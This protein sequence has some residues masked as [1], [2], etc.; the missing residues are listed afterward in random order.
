MSLILAIDQGTSSSRG[1]V[2][3]IGTDAFDRAAGGRVSIRGEAQR[4]F[5]SIFPHDG[6][7]E[8]DPEVI[9]QTTLDA[10]RAAIANAGIEGRDISAI[11]ITNQR[12]TTL[13]W[14][15]QTG[16]CVYNAIVWQ[17]RRT[18]ERCEQMQRDGMQRT[19]SAKTGL[20]LDPY[21]SGT[22]L[23][24]LLDE[25]P[26]L[27]QRVAGGE[28]CFGTVD[29]FLLWR[30]T[31]GQSHLTDATNASRTLLFDIGKQRWDPELLE[32]LNIEATLL[33]EVCDSAHDFG[34]ADAEWFG[35]AIPITGIAG[36]QQAALIGQGALDGGMCKSTCG[37]GCF[38]MTNTG[39]TQL[40]SDHGLLAT[41]GC[42]LDGKVTY[43]LEGSIFTAG[44]A[45]KWLRDKL[46][47]IGDAAETEAL[48]RSTGGDSGGVYLVPAFTGLG[49]PH[50]N[51]HVRGTI[52]G[53]T[54][55]STRAQI[56][57]ATLQS[58]V[59]Q[60]AEFAGRDGAGRRSSNPDSR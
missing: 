3:D 42:R 36:D 50:W 12:E 7:V 37:T 35:A 38:V 1:I 48:A 43:A 9:W 55:D 14:D 11:G 22:K 27:R 56:V 44:T 34:I 24:W 30:L 20:V 28:L 58:V 8:Q 6:W 23:A 13:V 39:A 16:Q 60:T 29:T 21:F 46:Q 49:A 2:F 5:D 15:K 10:C 31:K 26:G 59:F 33:P 45:V 40:D 25:R 32:Y 57:T 47:F 17:D 52:T 51:P 53:L 18:A 54:L 19:V 4:T 41:V